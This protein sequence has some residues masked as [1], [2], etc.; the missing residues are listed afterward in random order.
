[1]A[2]SYLGVTYAKL[3][4][5]QAWYIRDETYSAALADLVNAQFRHP[6]AA[7]WGN[8][9]TS[10][11]DGQNFKAVCFIIFMQCFF[12]FFFYLFVLFLFLSL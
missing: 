6:F 12:I 5:L 3:T 9:T 11:S 2:E 7:Y 4:W 10:S 8:G 1:M